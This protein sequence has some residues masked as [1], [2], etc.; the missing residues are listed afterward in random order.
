MKISNELIP[1]DLDGIYLRV[2]IDDQWANRCLTDMTWA[3]V[4]EWLE[5]KWQHLDSS[6]ETK[7]KNLE[8]IARHFHERLRALGDELDIRRE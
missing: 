1:R 2:Q 8:A 6:N 3:E 7:L 4:R 5:S